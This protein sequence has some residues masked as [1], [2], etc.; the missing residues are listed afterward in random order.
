MTA[1]AGGGL[2]VALATDWFLPRIGG[3]ELQLADLARALWD[4]G[5]A[6][7]VVTATPGAERINGIDVTRLQVARMPGAG[8]AISPLIVRRLRA[9]FIDGRY[10]VIHAHVSVVSP[11]GY[12]AVIAA[13]SLD[14]PAVLTFH[15]ALLRTIHLLRGF[16][17]LFGWSR[18]PIVVTAVSRLVAGQA[19]RAGGGIEVAVLPNGIDPE[20]WRLVTPPR[21]ESRREIVVVST[22]RL[23]RK[24]R[25]LELLSA[26]RTARSAVGAQGRRLL[27]R[28]AG[29]GPDRPRLERFIARHGLGGDVALLGM[30]S[31]E[32]LAEAY[33]ASDIFVLP[34]RR[35]AFGI[36]ALEAR[37]AGLPVIAMRDSGTAEFLSDE[38][39]LVAD[40][41]A[42]L[43]RLLTRL[44][45]DDALRQRLAP[46][47]AALD[48]FSW[49]SVVE[50]H[51]A[52]YARAAQL[53]SL[54]RAA[55]GCE[56]AAPRG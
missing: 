43:A 35:E 48:R 34:S 46:P 4:R 12:A 50:A 14:L 55:A 19:G 30:Q 26:F 33:A 44:A 42:A 6:V 5:C 36:A 7:R 8:F 52:C 45:L 29:N 9:E 51:L 28:I 49:H 39:T 23:H 37:C 1:S 27:L 25:A 11:V 18:W 56:A 20:Q 53:R 31:R 41:E 17:R 40:D 3:I 10:D 32:A 2:R 24:K 54:N 16:D 21:G 22:M 15:S 13:H 38:T 47:E